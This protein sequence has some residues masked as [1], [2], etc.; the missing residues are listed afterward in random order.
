MKISE[1][2]R[3]GEGGI[4]SGYLPSRTDWNWGLE[5]GTGI[6]D[7][8]W[9]LELALELYRPMDR[10]MDRTMDIGILRFEKQSLQLV[11][12]VNKQSLQLVRVVNKQKQKQKPLHFAF[13][14]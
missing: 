1:G 3:S 7:W 12:V 11:R 6:G 10:S 2:P 4:L 9:G 5:L 14:I 13:S 8:N